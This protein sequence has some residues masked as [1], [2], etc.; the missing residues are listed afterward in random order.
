MLQRLGIMMLFAKTS[1][2]L[3]GTPAR[4]AAKQHVYPIV[5]VSIQAQRNKNA[6]AMHVFR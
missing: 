5:K 3:D 2:V 4:N 1:L 6:V